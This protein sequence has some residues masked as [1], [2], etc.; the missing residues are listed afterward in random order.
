MNV[1][2][3]GGTGFTG[4]AL[5]RRLLAEGHAVTALCRSDGA[6]GAALRRGGAR[7]VHASVTDASAV[8]AC[9][10]G[11]RVVH[12]LAAAFRD[13]NASRDHCE[14]VNVEGTRIVLAAAR[15]H[16]VRRFVHCSTCGVHGH[17][18]HP[19]ADETAPL[20]PRD[21]YQRSKCRAEALVHAAGDDAMATTVLRPAAI[22]GPGDRG[23][24]AMLFR[25]V[26]RGRFPMF[27]S[28]RTLYHPVFIENLVDAYMLAMQP[29]RGAGG[30][31]L[32]ADAEYLSIE[33]LVHRVAAA[34]NVKVRVPHLPL[35]PLVAAGHVCEKLCRPL[36]IR[37]P[38][39]PRRVNWYRTSRAFDIGRARRELGY[40][41]RID[42][43]EGLRRT[44]E[45]ARAE[46]LL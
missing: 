46:G 30:T 37:P 43:D 1:L 22:Y 33:Q 35:G 38:L 28:G 10:A 26:A 45:W 11:A 21:D 24:Y 3:T 36:R 41:P 15:R 20:R 13:P 31:Y 2:V 17:V 34:L 27:G 12:H 14:H 25:R 32:I 16:G 6:G 39:Y 8:D 42:L 18:E 5:C 23:R 7:I 40:E 9:M 44:A 29:G 4:T 19:P